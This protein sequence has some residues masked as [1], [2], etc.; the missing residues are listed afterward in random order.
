MSFIQII[1]FTTSR[2]DEVRALSE[3]FRDSSENMGAVVRATMCRDRDQSDRYVNIVEFDSYEAAMEN[4][5]RPETQE[6]AQGMAELCDG[7]ARF[8][9]LD[10]AESYQA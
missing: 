2:P 7:P 6:F 4:S 1:E 9:N 8:S 5:N 3:K 10:V